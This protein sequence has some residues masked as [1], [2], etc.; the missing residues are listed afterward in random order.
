VTPTIGGR[1]LSTVMKA[2]GPA[3]HRTAERRRRGLP[4][5]RAGRSWPAW[6]VR[7]ISDRGTSRRGPLT[8]DCLQH[9]R[10]RYR[11][12]T[13]CDSSARKA[14]AVLSGTRK[15]AC[16]EHRA[17]RPHGPA[18]E[19]RPSAP[20]DPPA[21]A[22]ERPV[23]AGRG[24]GRGLAVRPHGPDPRGPVL[25]RAPGDDRRRPARTS[26]RSRPAPGRG[27]RPGGRPLSDTG[28][29]Q[30][31]TSENRTERT[32][33]MSTTRR[34]PH[35]PRPHAPVPAVLAFRATDHRPAPSP[36]PAPMKP[37]STR[38]LDLTSVRARQA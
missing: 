16:H 8:R 26:R 6:R 3:R 22:A 23:R 21:P 32:P 31:L 1:G 25:G 14:C 18:L 36:G 2:D 9:A 33:C 27:G 19:G 10:R 35:T 12:V 24:S 34:S 5:P 13:A 28:R 17:D 15:I 4:T 29:V 37:A 7:G 20:K 30:S 38:P 11:V